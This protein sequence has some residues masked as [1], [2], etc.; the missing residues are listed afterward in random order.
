[1]DSSKTMIAPS[2]LSANFVRLEEEIKAIEHAGADL[3]HVDVMDGHFVPNI[4]IGPP[5]VSSIRKVTKL[6]LDVHLMIEDPDNYIKEFAV[7][8]AD[9]LTVHVE[10]STHLNRTIHYIKEQGCK[11]GVCLNPATSLSTLDYVLDNVDMILIMTVNPGFGGQK[12]IPEV[13]LKISRLRELL[14]ERKRAVE[15]EV[16][17]GINL[18]NIGEVAKAGANIFVAGNAVFTTEDYSKTISELRRR[19]EL[20]DRRK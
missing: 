15:I 2:I 8:G 14:N 17:G 7:A 19:A 6:P 16:D 5:V 4:T 18:E 3:V 9:I 12:L 13:L 11:A 1:M 20:A 10:A